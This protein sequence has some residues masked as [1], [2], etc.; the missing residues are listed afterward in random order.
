MNTAA[1]HHNALTNAP[2]AMD[3]ASLIDPSQVC[4]V[5]L[6]GGRGSRMGGVDK[7]LQ[8]FRGQALALHALQRLRAQS[9]GA[10]RWLGVNAN[11][12]AAQYAAWGVPVWPDPVDGYLGPLAG[13]LAGLEAAAALPGCGYVLTVPCDSPLFPLDVLARLAQGLQQA[14]AEIAVAHAPETSDAPADAHADSGAAPNPLRSQPVFSLLRTSLLP[15]LQAFTAQGGRKIE[16]WMAQHR[17]VAVPFAGAHN[18][19][20]FS[21]ANTLADL[22]FLEQP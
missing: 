1:M 9:G 12:N 20:A 16:H 21:N 11:R 14:Q 19:R 13:F 17:T 6:A 2:A 4:A 10:P 7:G 8:P 3:N 22:A 18:A 5:V 15:S